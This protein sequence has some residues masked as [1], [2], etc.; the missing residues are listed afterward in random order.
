MSEI[1]SKA[2]WPRKGLAPRKE[3]KEEGIEERESLR[4]TP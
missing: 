3:K 1:F 2:A 4:A